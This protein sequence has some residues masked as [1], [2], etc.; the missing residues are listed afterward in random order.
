M[1]DKVRL[2][3]AGVAK[4]LKSAA[5]AEV[6]DAA[7]RQIAAAAGPDAEVEG[8]TTDR[9]AASV[10]VP[11]DQQAIGGALTRG[12]EALGVEVVQKS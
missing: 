10:S 5:F 3:N 12:A 7:A 2:N 6:V 9:G 11:A 4:L 1:A 8:Y